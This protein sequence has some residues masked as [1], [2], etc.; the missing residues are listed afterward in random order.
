MVE[1]REIEDFFF[2]LISSFVLN[3]KSKYHVEK[4]L[5][6]NSFSLNT[7]AKVL[8]FSLSGFSLE[9]E[10]LGLADWVLENYGND[11]FRSGAGYF[12]K[13]F[14]CD[15]DY[16]S[17]SSFNFCLFYDE[18]STIETICSQN[19]RSRESEGQEGSRNWG[20]D[21]TRIASTTKKDRRA[22]IVMILFASF[23]LL[24]LLIRAFW[25]TRK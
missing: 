2:R 18:D 11:A 9:D 12:V 8:R 19:G 25:Q 23:F 17:S 13:K 22:A 6:P 7:K 15:M 20:N 10:A 5:V 4:K 24:I 1:S 3:M 14:T 16:M 21:T